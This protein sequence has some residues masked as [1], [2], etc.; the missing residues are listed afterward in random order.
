[1]GQREM[2]GGCGPVVEYSMVVWGGCLQGHPFLHPSDCRGCSGE[3]EQPIAASL[4]RAHL[5]QAHVIANA[6]LWPLAAKP[7]MVAQL[8]KHLT[9]GVNVNSW[10]FL[11]VCVG[12]GLPAVPSI[13]SCL[14]H[15]STSCLSLMDPTQRNPV[16][17]CLPIHQ[18]PWAELLSELSSSAGWAVQAGSSRSC[19]SEEILRKLQIISQTELSI[20]IKLS[21]IL[22]LSLRCWMHLTEEIY[23]SS[24]YPFFLLSP[25]TPCCWRVQVLSRK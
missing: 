22:P 1:M 15:S 2:S 3:L 5:E 24:C 17:L 10:G 25:C 7:W 21:V 4:W 18:L 13:S 23:F 6:V 8:C 12:G 16:A 20:Q 9:K 19:V 14:L 11:C